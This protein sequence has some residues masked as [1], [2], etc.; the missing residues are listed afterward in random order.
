MDTKFR[1]RCGR[2]TASGAAFAQLLRF[3]QQ[4]LSALKVTP[5]EVVID[6]AAVSPGATVD[7]AVEPAR[8]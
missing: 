3:S 4:A 5:D 7:D 1:P 8:S 6:P 2:P